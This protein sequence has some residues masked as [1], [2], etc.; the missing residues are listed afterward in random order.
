M[1]RTF[2]IGSERAIVA[3]NADDCRTV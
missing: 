2:R 3:V 1:C